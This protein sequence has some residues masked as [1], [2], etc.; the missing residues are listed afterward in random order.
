MIIFKTNFIC[1]EANSFLDDTM[2]ILYSKSMRLFVGREFLVSHLGLYKPRHFCG[3]SSLRTM[4]DHNLQVFHPR[5]DL[6][7][8]ADTWHIFFVS[9][10]R[11]NLLD[12]VPF[13]EPTQSNNKRSVDLPTMHSHP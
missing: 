2:I 6:S 3:L 10:N 1:L 12:V 4:S 9:C 13:T 5:W 11:A 8:L 7:L